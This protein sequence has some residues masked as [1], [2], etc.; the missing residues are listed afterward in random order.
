MNP[1]LNYIE[2]SNYTSFSERLFIN[3]V[4]GQASKV[5]DFYSQAPFPGYGK[6]DTAETLFLRTKDNNFLIEL[7]NLIVPGSN[8]LEIGCGT[9]Q[10]SNFLASTSLANIYGV[11]ASIESLKVADGFATKNNLSRVKFIRDDIFNLSNYPSLSVDYLWCSG[12]LH[13]TGDTW[14]A[15]DEIQKLVKPG[16]YIFIGLYNRFGRFFTG[17][18]QYLVSILGDSIRTRKIVSMLDPVLSSL[19]QE[20]PKW[21][22]WYRDQYLHPYETWHSVNELAIK[23][24][25]SDF[26]IVGSIPNLN[27]DN[28]ESGNPIISKTPIFFNQALIRFTELTMPFTK[29]GKEGALFMLIGRKRL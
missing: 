29:F 14:R 28:L 5:S 12:V 20:S 16:G 15:Y 22:A 8:F 6:D 21:I 2:N 17:V 23:L 26:D 1:F 18:R 13:H 7:K 24:K 9:G 19:E 11:D 3:N 25:E 27:F 4:Y 10:L